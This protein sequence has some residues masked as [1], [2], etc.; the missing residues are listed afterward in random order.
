MRGDGGFAE[1]VGELARDPFGHAPGV[2]E[3]QRR[4]VL[5]DELG[6]ASVDFRPHLV[7]HH[8]LERRS[9]NFQAQIA[10]ALMPRVDDRDLC[11]RRAVRRGA[12]EKMGDGFDRVLRRREADPLQAVAA[13][14][15]EPFQRQ[16]E[17]GAAFV[18]RDSVDF[19]DDHRPGVS[20]HRAPGL[21]TKQNVERFRRRHQD[22]RR[23]AAHP[24]A[25][26][27]GR[28]ARSDPGA[29]FDVGKTAPAQLLAD[30]SQ[31]RFEVAMDVVRQ[32]LEGRD[33]DDLRRIRER[34]LETLSH[35][36]VDR[37]QK[38]RE[39]LAR[40]RRRGD[41]G[42]AAGLDRRPRFGLRGGGRGETVGEPVRNRWVEQRFEGAR[43]SRRGRAPSRAVAWRS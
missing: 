30:P 34:R 21:R 39:R 26:G 42:V 17:M 4:A 38:G 37:R 43:G 41:E 24:V 36:V 19:V 27:R 9:W 15:L 23:A 11:G 35:Q 5:R 28:V 8:R 6:Q 22:V 13:Q 3:H 25:L 12:G 32:R 14:S 16:S 33:V 40:S 2:D 31:R 20:Q 1:T 7:R 10:P 29:N 18:R